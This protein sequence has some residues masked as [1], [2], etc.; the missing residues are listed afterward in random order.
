M[1][2]RRTMRAPR[3]AQVAA[4]ALLL[5]LPSSAYALS[6]GGVGTTLTRHRPFVLRAW[7]WH[8][9]LAYGGDAVVSGS[10]TPVAGRARVAL[11]YRAA[12]APS[13]RMIGA[14]K[15]NPNGRFTLRAPVRQSGL[16]RVVETAIVAD[17]AEP[18]ISTLAGAGPIATSQPAPIGVTAAF[19]VPERQ[20]DGVAGQP[21]TLSGRLL[22]GTPGRVIRLLA[23]AGTR[24]T[25]LTETRTGASGGFRLRFALPTGGNRSLRVDFAGDRRNRAA[26]AGAGG[27]LGFT[28]SVASWYDD[29][30]STA[31]GF[32]ATYGV[33]NRT[34]PCGTHVTLSYEG[35]T[36]V[37]TVDDRGP[38]VWG[39]DYDLNQNTAAAL[40]MSGVATVL[41]S[42]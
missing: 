28:E 37:A 9:Q 33:A 31:C 38:Y 41:S 40:G 42:V 4:G 27:A 25:T 7:P 26:A 14:G 16:L 20:L 34:L 15:S 23:G 8:E 22:P 19:K 35:R 21:V 12:G 13:W 36:V 6:T 29:A 2:T 1:R 3:A 30:G 5:A 11:E 32:H 18:D 17:A 24:W 10:T 39:R